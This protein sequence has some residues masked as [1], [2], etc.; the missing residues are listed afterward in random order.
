MRHRIAE[1][2]YLSALLLTRLLLFLDLLLNSFAVGHESAIRSHRVE[3]SHP[4]LLLDELQSTVDGHGGFGFI[5]LQKDGSD[6]LVDIG[7]V[8]QLVELGLYAL[9]L[10]LLRLQL[11]AG[12]D[13]TLELWQRKQLDIKSRRNKQHETY[14]SAAAGTRPKGPEAVSGRPWL[15]LAG[16]WEKG[17]PIE[18]L[19]ARQHLLSLPTSIPSSTPTVDTAPPFSLFFLLESLLLDG[20]ALA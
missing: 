17:K 14:R 3:S 5:L 18:L 9:V 10:L 8:V 7:I 2:H 19:P 6:K 1:C 20:V 15:V 4:H 12:I 11:L 16:R 13:Q